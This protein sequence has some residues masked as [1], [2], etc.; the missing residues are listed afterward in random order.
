[1]CDIGRHRQRIEVLSAEPDRNGLPVSRQLPDEVP[2]RASVR[3]SASVWPSASVRT[4]ASER[5]LTPAR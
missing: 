5:T 2:V 3:P 4:L 1:M